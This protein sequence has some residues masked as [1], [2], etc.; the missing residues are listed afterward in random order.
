MTLKSKLLLLVFIPLLCLLLLAMRIALEKVVQVRDMKSLVE[1]TSIST[2]IGALVHELQ[3]ERGMSAGFI[4]SNG[5]NFAADLPKQR[6]EVDKRKVELDQ[7]LVQVN[8]AESGGLLRQDLA[9]ATKRLDSLATIRQSITARSIT[10]EEAIGYY[11]NAIGGLLGMVGKMASLSSDAGITR[12]AAAY[13]SLLQAKESAG[14]ERA[15]LSNVLGA[16]RFSPEMLS[17]F[18]SVSSAQETWIKAF[19]F[20]A[21]PSQAEFFKTTVAGPA[22]EEVLQ[23]KKAAMEKMNEPSLGMDAKNW[24][25]KSTTRIDLLKE[26][27]DRLASDLTESAEN[28]M[29]DARLLVGIYASLAILSIAVTV[30]LAFRLIRGI[31]VQIGGEPTE[32]VRIAH[33]IAAGDLTQ[34]VKIASADTTSMLAS[35]REMQNKLREMVISIQAEAQRVSTTASQLSTSSSQVAESSHQQ[36]EAAASMA[37]AVEEWTV[38][39]GHVSER[40]NEATHISIHSGDLS[41]QGAEVVHS[42]AAEMQRIEASV[43]ESSEIVGAL[44]RQSI[45]ISAIVNVIKEIA[46]QTNLLALNAAIEAARAGE[47]GRGFAIVA[48]EVRKLAERTTQSTQEIAHVIDQVQGSTRSAASSMEAGVTQAGRGAKLATEAGNS[49]LGI[50]S[51]SARVVE[52]VGDISNSLREQSAASND[53]ARNIES[54]AQMVEENSAAV[55]ETSSA[56]QDLGKMAIALRVMVNQFRVA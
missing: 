31:L 42:A 44:E 55:Q 49:I 26:V 34:D 8:V 52:V 11:T 20:Y 5:A 43:K 50:K 19:N 48:D 21:R 22:V 4:G 2:R 15:T 23:I 35:I 6:A 27:E 3:R 46:D 47:Q 37:A 40:S 24:F 28:L 41:Q 33:A 10:G 36:S 39:I 1:L 13:S 12:L 25:A 16:D 7:R 56:A 9:E 38:S 30:I 32:A 17:R 18:I 51:E 53:I 54:I 29:N 45:Q 14:I